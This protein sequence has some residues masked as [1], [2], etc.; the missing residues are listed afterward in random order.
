MVPPRDPEAKSPDAR[1]GSHEA[2]ATFVGV[3]WLE[4]MP[5][6]RAMSVAIGDTAIALFNVEGTIYAIDDACLH[7]GGSLGSGELDGRIVRCAGHGWTYDV[8]TGCMVDVP[9]LRVATRAVKVV[10]GR[11]MVAID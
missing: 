7:A 10:D 8:T 1:P 5:P 3:V 9:E 11:I 6:G 4:Q 2:P